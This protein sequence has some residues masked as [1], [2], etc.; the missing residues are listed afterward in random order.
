MDSEGPE[1]TPASDENIKT[2]KYLTEER[3]VGTTVLLQTYTVC[4]TPCVSDSV[5]HYM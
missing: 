4:G 2:E 1:N 3:F 5:S